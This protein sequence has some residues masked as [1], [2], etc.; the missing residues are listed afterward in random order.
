MTP[1]IMLEIFGYL[2]MV[3]V[4][5]SFLLTDIKWLRVVNMTGGLI[6]LIYGIL[7]ETWPTAMLNASLVTINGF[8]LTKT[9][10]KDKRE[11]SVNFGKD[12]EYTENDNKKEENI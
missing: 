7:T 12:I 9:I 8:H 6:C 3:V 4:L 10:I 1:D 2:G 5:I 11:K